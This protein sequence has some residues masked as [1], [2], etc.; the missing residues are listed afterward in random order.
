MT[1][2][3]GTLDDISTSSD[4]GG[5]RL[6][7]GVNPSEYPDTFQDSRARPAPRRAPGAQY[8]DTHIIHREVCVEYVGTHNTHVVHM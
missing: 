4:E 5:E 1:K 3:I 7:H 2:A 8:P 6:E